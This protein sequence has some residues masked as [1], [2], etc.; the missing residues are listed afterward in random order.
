MITREDLKNSKMHFTM[1]LDLSDSYQDHYRN[2]AYPRLTCFVAMPRRRGS[3][4]EPAKRFFVDGIE[5][6]GCRE[7]LALL[8][9]PALSVVGGSEA[10]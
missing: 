6:F 4:V 3:K 7:L 2:D 8:N 1:H 10:A 9:A 5:V